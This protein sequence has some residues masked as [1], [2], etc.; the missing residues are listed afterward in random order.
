MSLKARLRYI[1]GLLLIFISLFLLYFFKSGLYVGYSDY[2]PKFITS[3]KDTQ[4][5]RMLDED[6]EYYDEEDEYYDE[7]DEYYDEDDEEYYEDGED[8]GKLDGEITL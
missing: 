3:S 1:G 6:D 8:Y 7:D 5:E 2:L 4:E